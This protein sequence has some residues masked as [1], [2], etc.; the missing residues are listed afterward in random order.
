MVGGAVSLP[1]FDGRALFRAMDDQRRE[2]DLGWQGMADAVWGLAHELN[3]AQPRSRPIAVSTIRRLEREGETTCQ[4]ALFFLRWL[5]RAPEEEFLTGPV[6]DVGSTA[7]PAC[8][9]DRRLRWDVSGMGG[10]LDEHRQSMGVTWAELANELGCQPSQ[11]S[12]LRRARFGTRMS[13]A[14]RCVQWLGSPAAAF[15]H[16]R[17]W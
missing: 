10:V 2:R 9:P 13:L 3:A 1:E 12:G 4:H 15:V 8:G 14:M 11:V 6:R 5:G 17:R 16:P 7:L